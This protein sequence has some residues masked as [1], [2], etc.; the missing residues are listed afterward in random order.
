MRLCVFFALHQPLVSQRRAGVFFCLRSE[1]CCFDRPFLQSKT[2]PSQTVSCLRLRTLHSS[3]KTNRAVHLRECTPAHGWAAG[4]NTP[5]RDCSGSLDETHVSRSTHERLDEPAAPG[6]GGGARRPAGP[7]IREHGLGRG[8]AAPAGPTGAG[9]AAG[10]EFRFGRVFSD[11][12]CASAPDLPAAAESPWW[13]G[14]GF[15]NMCFFCGLQA[16]PWLFLCRFVCDGCSFVVSFFAE[17]AD[18]CFG[19]MNSW[20]EV[21]FCA[22]CG[23]NGWV[24][25]RHLLTRLLVCAQLFAAEV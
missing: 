12:A 17:H 6:R 20:T 13:E 1:F 25:R 16:C 24:V 23:A 9:R 5:V 14:E 21:S 11:A 18:V 3:E 19:D 10:G 4:K 15:T 2:K 8:G 22:P 7:G